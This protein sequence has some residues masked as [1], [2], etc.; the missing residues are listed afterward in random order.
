[1]NPLLA[2]RRRL[3]NHIESHGKQI[4]QLYGRQGYGGAGGRE[5]GITHN[6]TCWGRGRGSSTCRLEGGRSSEEIK[7]NS[8]IYNREF[9]SVTLFLDGG[10]F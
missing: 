7:E 6:K 1:V 2:Y 10:E 8:Y 9:G 3:A 4:S 5:G